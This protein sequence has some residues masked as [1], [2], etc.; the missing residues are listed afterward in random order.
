MKEVL[1]RPERCV[2][3]KSCELACVV[4]H[5]VSKSLL[6]AISETNPPTKLIFTG[7][8][9][10]KKFALNCR[11]CE[12][13]LCLQVCPTSALLKEKESG[14]VSHNQE[15]CIGC[16]MC[17]I[18]CPFGIISQR[19]NSKT[20]VKCDRCPDLNI[21]ACVEACP[22]QALL[23]LEPDEVMQWKRNS[24]AQ[25]IFGQERQAVQ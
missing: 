1:L 2:G 10:G 23:F 19:A 20:I 24:V 5:S 7:V 16:G 6:G 15:L 21:P 25:Q 12:Y 4:T 9:E 22:T 18:S 3:C 14:I 13:P 11:H 17:Q 8:W